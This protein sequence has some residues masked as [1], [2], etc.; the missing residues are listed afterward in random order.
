[1]WDG[2]S[3]ARITF[4]ASELSSSSSMAFLTENLN[5]QRALLRRLESVQ[6]IKLLDNVKVSSIQRDKERGGWPLVHLSDG[7]VMRTRL[8]VN[9]PYALFLR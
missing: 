6:E 1:M 9:I 5:L 4:S 7:K 2:I 3:D 8:L